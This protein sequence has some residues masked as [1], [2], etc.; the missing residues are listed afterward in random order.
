M[1]PRLL[2]QVSFAPQMQQQA[3][4]AAQGGQ[5]MGMRRTPSQQALMAMG[6]ATAAGT[7]CKPTAAGPRSYCTRLHSPHPSPLACPLVS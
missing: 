5:A 7:L 6:A 2:H 1:Y 4:A 3:A